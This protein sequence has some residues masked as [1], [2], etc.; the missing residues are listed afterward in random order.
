M[1]KKIHKKKLTEKYSPTNL[2]VG[3]ERGVLFEII[4]KLHSVIL[5]RLTSEE[6]EEEKVQDSLYDMFRDNKVLFTA[7]SEHENQC[8]K[9]RNEAKS[10]ALKKLTKEEVEL[11]EIPEH[12]QDEVFFTDESKKL[13]V[14]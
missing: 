9:V 6:R 12:I 11:L 3:N 5:Y 7:F 13:K 2:E 8:R 4:E 14:K 10:K 1:K